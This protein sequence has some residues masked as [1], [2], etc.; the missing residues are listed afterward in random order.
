MATPPGLTALLLADKLPGVLP[1]GHHLPVTTSRDNL[2]HPDGT[3]AAVLETSLGAGMAVLT[4]LPHPPA[5]LL[6][7]IVLVSRVVGVTGELREGEGCYY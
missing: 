2:L 6:A 1:A 4:V 5:H 7:A 3:G